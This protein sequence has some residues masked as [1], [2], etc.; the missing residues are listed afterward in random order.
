MRARKISLWSALRE[1]EKR[2]VFLGLAFATLLV[3]AAQFWPRAPLLI[4][5]GGIIL[6][7]LFFRRRLPGAAI[8]PVLLYLFGT[9]T[10]F[11]FVSRGAWQIAAALFFGAGFAALIAR[12]IFPREYPTWSTI[13][14]AIIF[15]YATAA[16]A[17][18]F[19]HLYTPL[20]AILLLNAAVAAMLVWHALSATIPALT[21]RML[22]AG[23]ISLIVAELT[24]TLAFWPVSYLVSGGVIFVIFYFLL[25]VLQ[26]VTAGTATKAS[27]RTSA[28][29][30]LSALLLILVTARW[31][32]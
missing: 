3:L 27:L 5:G 21:E 26:N 4:F 2:A 23:V 18:L 11:L 25:S 32:V 16:S 31:T 24:W 12:G 22:V 8:M 29:V 28:L 30:A 20:P 9:G 1:N 13:F 7:L 14:A 6:L 19:F 10:L 17:G 15:F